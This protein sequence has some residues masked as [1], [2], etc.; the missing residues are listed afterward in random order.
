[1]NLSKAVNVIK[2]YSE[3]KHR[4]WMWQVREIVTG[5]SRMF[6]VTVCCY[7]LKQPLLLFLLLGLLPQMSIMKPIIISFTFEMFTFS[8]QLN[9]IKQTLCINYYKIGG[10]IILIPPPK[11]N[12]NNK[13]GNS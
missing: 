6:A 7:E 4:D 12:K 5:S 13:S 10:F 1:M 9:T 11:K 3:M 8:L 2:Y